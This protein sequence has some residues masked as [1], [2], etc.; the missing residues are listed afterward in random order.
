[1]VAGP[2]PAV[3]GLAL[4]YV[5]SLPGLLQADLFSKVLLVSLVFYSLDVSRW[6]VSRDC[7]RDLCSLES[8]ISSTIPN[9]DVL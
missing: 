7:C 5:S 3:P 9:S 2:I 1:V 4:P 8:L 6:V